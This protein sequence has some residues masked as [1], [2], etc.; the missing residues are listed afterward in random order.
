MWCMM[1][2]PLMLGLDLRRIKKGDDL[3]NI[4]ANKDLIAINQDPLGIQ[5]KRVFC[6]LCKA[7]PDSTYV[8]D[9]DRVDILVK[10]MSGNR[11]AVSFINVSEKKK[12]GKFSLDISSL[13]RYF[14]DYAPS[15]G[16]FTVRDVWTGRESVCNDGIITAKDL[17]PC[18]NRTFILTEG[19][20]S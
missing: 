9:I 11:L 16:S 19:K 10:P 18:E 6:S 17:A 13:K 1:N 4:I 15:S 12:K 7:R 2:S 3:Y 8:R 20:K 14:K 5:A